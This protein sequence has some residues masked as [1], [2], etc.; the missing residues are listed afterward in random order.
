M[1]RGSDPGHVAEQRHIVGAM[2]KLEIANQQAV[3]LAAEL[4]VLRLVDVAED[5]AVIPGAAA[6]FSQ[7]AREFPLADVE[8]LDLHAGVTLGGA[9]Q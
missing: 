2:I 7:R 3:G 1:R 8:H 4:S 6:K 5:R 9:H